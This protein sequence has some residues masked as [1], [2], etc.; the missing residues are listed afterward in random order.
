MKR[1]FLFSKLALATLLCVSASSVSAAA[2]DSNGVPVIKQRPD[3]QLRSAESPVGN[4]YAV[5]PSYYGIQA[6]GDAFYGK[7][8]PLSGEVTALHR[9]EVFSNQAESYIQTGLVLNDILYIPQLYYDEVGMATQQSSIIWKRFNVAT[10]ETLA[11]INFGNT[12]EAMKMFAYSMT[13]DSSRNK[14]Y[15]LKYDIATD[16][17]GVLM[18]IDC[19]GEPETWRAKQL[20][21]CNAD[22]DSWVCNVVYNPVDRLLYSFRSDGTLNT[23]DVDANVINIVPVMEYDDMELEYPASDQTTSMV[24]SPRDHAFF[25]V[26][27]SEGSAQIWAIDAETYEVNSDLGWMSPYGF[28]S[29]LYCPDPYADDNAPDAMSMPVF[30]FTDGALTG[31]VTVTAPNTLFSGEQIT[32]NNMSCNIVVD[33]KIADSFPINAGQTLS[34]EITMTQGQHNVEIYCSLPG[35]KG[36]STSSK[37]Y[38]GNDT[39]TAPRRVT[40]ADGVLSWEGTADK[41]IHNGYIN[42]NAVR[43]DVYLNGKK[44]NS[45]PLTAT[46]CEFVINETI[47]KRSSVTVTASAA[48]LTS[49]H[50]A[51]LS[52]MLGKGFTLPLTLTPD[53]GQADLFE[54]VNPGYNSYSFEYVAKTDSDPDM[55]RIYIKDTYLNEQPNDWLFLPPVYLDSAEAIYELDYTYA[56]ARLNDRWLDNLEILIGTDPAPE[57]MQESLY[58]HEA[59]LQSTPA[60]ESVKFTV[61]KPGTYYIGFHEKPDPTLNKL[62]R[63]ARFYDFTVKK[64][65]ANTNAPAKLDDFAAVADPVGELVINVSATLPLKSINGKDLDASKPLTFTAFNENESKTATGLPGQKVNV[66]LAVGSDGFS[67]VRAYA[68]SDNGDGL[69][70]VATVYVGYDEPLPPTNLKGVISDD[71]MSLTFSWDPIPAVGANGG[72]VDLDEVT[73]DI[74][75]VSINGEAKLGTS[76]KNNSYTIST[77]SLVQSQYMLTPVAVNSIGHSVNGTVLIE[78]LGALYKLPMAEEFPTGTF[79]LKPWKFNTVA[80]FTG[81]DWQHASGMED[82]AIGS[83][84]FQQNGAIKAVRNGRSGNVGELIAPK[85]TTSGYEHVKLFLRYWDCPVSGHLEVWGRSNASQTF[86]KVAEVDPKRGLGSWVDWEINLDDAKYANKPWVQFNI[87]TRLD[88]SNDIALIDNYSLLQNTEYDFTAL[89]VE[90]PVSTIVG[91]KAIFNVT[92]A[93]SGEESS[94]GTLK[95]DLLG[96]GIVLDTKEVQIGRLQPGGMFLY[97]AEFEML[98]DYI[99]YEF[100]EVRASATCPNDQNNRNNDCTVEFVLT[101]C[102]VPVVRDL[103]AVRAENGQD[104]ELTWSQ[105]DNDYPELESFEMILPLSINDNLGRFQNVDLD[106][107]EPFTLTQKRWANDDKPCAWVAFNDVDFGTSSDPRLCARTGDQALIARSVAYDQTTEEPKR[108]FDW[109]ISPEVVSGS[110]VS[111]WLNT[112]SVDYTE[113]VQIWYSSTDTLLDPDNIVTDENGNPRECGSFKWI[114]NFTKSGAETW[115]QCTQTLP[116]DAKYFAIV[117]A[118]YGQFGAVIDDLVFEEKTPSKINIDSYNVYCSIDGGDPEEVGTELTDTHFTHKTTDKTANTYYVVTN[119]FDEE[120]YF[121]SAFS[122]PASVS[123]T[124]VDEITSGVEVGAGNGRIIVAGARGLNLSLYDIDGRVVINKTVTSDRQ[125]FLCDAGVYLANVGGRTF[126]LI[127]R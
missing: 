9:G 79:N 10:G 39:P 74:Y 81:V 109:L 25:W 123:A 98:E 24:Y 72:F 68:T 73:Y 20:L 21:D 61:D 23:I 32:T 117:Y 125:T 124:G 67:T 52:R 110:E 78:S 102:Q 97:E 19:T 103:K 41:G 106:G 83:P 87:R 116:A 7:L 120:R 51:P 2:L 115:E 96:E 127:V 44:F 104:V 82:P 89:S 45:T 12:E 58:S 105:P 6:Y 35:L 91:E 111:F 29:T 11:P 60:T 14:I 94:T 26:H 18:E 53:A 59:R 46:S 71:N 17:G 15:A 126:K 55:F 37:I 1:F 56:N 121:R 76:G 119:V 42:K 62:Y 16:K 28:V 64:N 4:L 48:G 113:T 47:D 38:V 99:N 31:K 40:L 3:N 8:N 101:D 93:N 108:S 107:L 100:L 54:I 22:S 34:R 66:T 90:A 30:D 49:A 5:V 86:E 33:G 57:K 50:S 88:D 69:Q 122:N 70:N 92:V 85:A 114:R 36:A 84:T 112:L 65:E 43:Y 95:V 27:T 13:Y 77:R 118:S 80:P 75:S 63:G